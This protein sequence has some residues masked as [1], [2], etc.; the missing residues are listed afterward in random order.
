MTE[1]KLTELQTEIVKAVKGLY[2][3]GELVKLAELA[4]ILQAPVARVRGSIGGLYKREVLAK[5]K[6][7]FTLVG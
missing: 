5:A 3:P 6:G 7:G 4:D 2:K 1:K